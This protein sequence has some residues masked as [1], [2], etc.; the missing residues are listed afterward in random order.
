MANIELVIKIPETIYKYIMLIQS[1]VSEIRSDKSLL[2]KILNAIITGIPFPKGHGDLVDV[3]DIRVIKLEDSVDV[4]I[5]A[6]TIIKADKESEELEMTKEEATIQ[7]L[8]S[9]IEVLE[10]MI[11]TLKQEPKTC[12]LNDAREEFIHDVY[13]TLDFLPTNDEANWIIESFDRATSGIK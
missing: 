1:Y 12:S 11:K 10:E 13:N 5:D 6:P 8:M 3:N 9:H 4:Y 7:S 2:K